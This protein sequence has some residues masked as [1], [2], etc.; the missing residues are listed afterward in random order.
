MNS[1]IAKAEGPDLVLDVSFVCEGC[2]GT[3]R[4]RGRWF[5]LLV[6]DFYCSTCGAH[7]L[8]V[9]KVKPVP[10][11]SRVMRWTPDAG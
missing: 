6:R 8:V 5:V 4:W 1:E 3:K 7:S 9:V 11:A 2:E 10:A